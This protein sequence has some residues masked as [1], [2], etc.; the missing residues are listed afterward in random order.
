MYEPLTIWLDFD[1][2]IVEHA[3]P[4]IGA[5]N[6]NAIEVVEKLLKAGHRVVLN[7]TRIEFANGTFEEA[8]DFLKEQ[9]IDLAEYTPQKLYPLPFNTESIALYQEVFIDDM[10]THM[11]LT[12]CNQLQGT[13][14]D[15]VTLERLFLERGWI[16]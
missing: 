14:V 2:T 13:M 6:P 5:L 4:A 1:G 15:W 11:P 3:Y 10:A 16:S 12:F 9:G 7:T 8:L